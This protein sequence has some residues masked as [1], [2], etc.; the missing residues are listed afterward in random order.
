MKGTYHSNGTKLSFRDRGKG[1]TV[2]FLHPTPLD[3][4]YWVPM[5]DG[6]AGVRAIAPDLRGH[7]ASELGPVD[8]LPAGGFALVPD[9]PAL[10]VTQLAADVL[11]LLDHLKIEEAVFAGCSIGGYVLLELW[12]RRRNGCRAGVCVFQAAGGCGSKPG[13]ARREHCA[14]ARE[15]TGRAV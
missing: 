2:V 10:T 4:A 5:V 6:L 12:R 14:G 9:A 11:A 7:G 8:S 1:Q 15:G 3:H 13:E